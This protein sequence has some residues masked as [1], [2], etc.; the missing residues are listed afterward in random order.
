MDRVVISW[1]AM[2]LFCVLIVGVFA[3]LFH[4]NSADMDT[5]LQ[6]EAVLQQTLT[7]LQNDQIALTGQIKQIGTSSYIEARAREDYAFLKPGELRFEIVNPEVLEGY[8]RDEL[9][10]LM[11]E[12][13]M[14]E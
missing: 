2:I 5:A 1:K 3:F 4:T 11:D 14:Y 10:I 7:R 9:Q 8:T 13:A 12:M 6:Q